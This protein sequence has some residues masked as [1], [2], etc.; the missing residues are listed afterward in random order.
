[1]RLTEENEI[2]SFPTFLFVDA[3]EKKLTL[4]GIQSYSK[5]EEVI[6]QLIPS[7]VKKK[8]S[9]SGIHLFE[10]YN[11]MTTSEFAFLNDISIKS[12]ETIIEELFEKGLIEKIENK[13]GFIWIHKVK[14]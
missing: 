4:K 7:A 8:W 6:Q 12:A 1:M 14:D 13:N 10:K 3:L 5:F 2:T 9:L 11:N